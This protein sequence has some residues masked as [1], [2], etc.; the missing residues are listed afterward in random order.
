M[1]ASVDY[2][3]VAIFIQSRLTD[4]FDLEQFINRCKTAM[5]LAISHDRLSFGRTNTSQLPLECLCISGIQ[6]DA[7][8]LSSL[9]CDRFASLVFFR[10][11]CRH[12]EG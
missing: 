3:L 7:H 6:V 12:S 10:F 9:H 5:G 1:P 11:D 8:S 4:T 2:Q